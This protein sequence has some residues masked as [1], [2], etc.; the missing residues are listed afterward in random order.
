M[1]RTANRERRTSASATGWRNRL[2]DDIRPTMLHLNHHGARRLAIAQRIEGDSPR[3]PG[4]RG[5]TVQMRQIL[6]H[7][8]PVRTHRLQR[9]Q[10][11]QQWRG[12]GRQSDYDGAG[13]HSIR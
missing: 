8:A 1:T 6:L 4:D 12:A 11:I 9:S 2:V 5:T 10:R 3:R 13:W 7:R